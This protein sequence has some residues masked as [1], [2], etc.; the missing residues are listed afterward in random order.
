MRMESG[1]GGVYGCGGEM[2]GG[3]LIGKRG[4]MWG[5]AGL[6]GL[7]RVRGG[8]GVDVCLLALWISSVLER[9]MGNRLLGYSVVK[10][11]DRDCLEQ[12][13]RHTGRT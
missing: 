12:E 7:A 9:E 3:G 4:R 8:L 5:K 11:D 10:M 6:V 2:G 13:E 1:R